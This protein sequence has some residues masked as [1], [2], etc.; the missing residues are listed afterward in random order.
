MFHNCLQL[1]PSFVHPGLLPHGVM[2]GRSKKGQAVML[3]GHLQQRFVTALCTHTHTTH[4]HA[5]CYFTQC[6]H[7]RKM[8][9]H[10]FPTHRLC[11]RTHIIPFWALHAHGVF[12]TSMLTPFGHNTL[13]HNHT[14]CLPLLGTTLT[15]THTLTLTQEI[16]N[17]QEAAQIPEQGLNLSGS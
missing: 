7:T 13:P 4:T 12:H 14:Q 8:L 15:L 16:C 1:A 11:S 9:T 17:L 3:F 10:T 2:C 6:T 5:F